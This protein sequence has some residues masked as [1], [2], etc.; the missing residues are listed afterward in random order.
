M[1]SD[2]TANGDSVDDVKLGLMLSELR[3]PAMKLLWQRFAE[4]ANAEGWPAGRFL[5][6][7]AEHE[8][9][10]R[11][12]RRIERHLREAR[13]LP[14]K[15]L[16]SFGFPAVP[17]I[18]KAQVMALAAGDAWI[19][20]GAN[21]LIFGPPGTGKS[22]LASALGLALVET[23]Y[24]VLF[25]RT[26]DLVQRLQRARHD[27]ALENMLARLDKFDLLILDDLAYVRKDQAETSV[28]F[29]LISARY[30]R[31]SLPGRHP[32]QEKARAARHNR[33]R[34]KQRRRR[35][36]T[37]LPRPPGN[38]PRAAQFPDGRS[39]RDAKTVAEPPRSWGAGRPRTPRPMRPT[40]RTPERRHPPA[41]TVTRASAEPPGAA[42]LRGLITI[43]PPRREK[44]CKKTAPN[45]PLALHPPRASARHP[46][47]RQTPN[48]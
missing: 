20:N 36:L 18:S 25:F 14:E 19:R 42:H 21:L 40:G 27:L 8:R 47:N 33:H 5:A 13:L 28:L 26:T 43:G 15:T 32:A 9:V 1:S 34:Q 46:E 6:C 37:I 35:Q 23:G 45:V 44:R 48:S 31:R 24:R 38:P 22:H 7:L 17:V 16:A 41:A 30:E 12:R 39:W 29:E 11:D 4:R 3:L 2:A 10:E